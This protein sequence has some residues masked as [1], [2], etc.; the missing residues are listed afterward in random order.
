F[1]YPVSFNGKVRFKIEL[2]ANL[3]SKEVEIAVLEH[4]KTPKYLDGKNPKKII[5]IPNRI[6]NIVL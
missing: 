2:P 3:S 4:E 1:E 6:V 5:V